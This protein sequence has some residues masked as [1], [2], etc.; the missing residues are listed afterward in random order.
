ML[1]TYNGNPWGTARQRKQRIKQK[2]I[3]IVKKYSVQQ[4]SEKEEKSTRERWDKYKIDIKMIDLNSAML[5]IKCKWPQPSCD[6]LG[7]VI[8][9]RLQNSHPVTV[10]CSYD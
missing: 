2:V 6:G 8:W 5:M 4:K 9:A 7:C 1:K 10:F 3:A